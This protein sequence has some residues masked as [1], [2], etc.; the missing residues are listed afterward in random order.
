MAFPY[1]NLLWGLL[2]L[3]PPASAQNMSDHDA[4]IAQI[5]TAGQNLTNTRRHAVSIENCI[6]TASVHERGN[7]GQFE[8]RR[9]VQADVRGISIPVSNEKDAE[10]F[11]YIERGTPDQS[12]GMSVTFFRMLPPF[13]AELETPFSDDIALPF[14]PSPRKAR[15]RFVFKRHPNFTIVHEDLASADKPRAFVKYLRA[16][17]DNYCRVIG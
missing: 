14:R 11:L 9:V 16:Y 6:M 15:E 12:A 13:E 17:R 8:L 10:R 7:N 2:A 1:H 5:E 4:L 3:T